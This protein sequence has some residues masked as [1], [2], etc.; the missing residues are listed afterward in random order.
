[1]G[2]DAALAVDPVPARRHAG[3]HG[4]TPLTARRDPTGRLIGGPQGVP[5][6]GG[7]LDGVVVLHHGNDRE[8]RGT[9]S[10]GT[11]DDVRVPVGPAQEVN[12]EVHGGL[13][14]SR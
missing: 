12:V 9:P 4:P 13:P 5:P 11:L 8:S 3:E 14:F 1:M 7:G 10:G 6:R 2:R